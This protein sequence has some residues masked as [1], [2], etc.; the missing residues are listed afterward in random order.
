MAIPRRMAGTLA[1]T[2]ADA[3]VTVTR[4]T[5]AHLAKFEGVKPLYFSL[6]VDPAQL[7]GVPNN[8]SL[9]A[10]FNFAASQEAWRWWITGSITGAAAGAV[11]ETHKELYVPSGTPLLYEEE[12]TV[13]FDTDNT[14]GISSLL[15]VF[16]YDI[17]TTSELEM[18]QERSRYI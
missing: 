2:G 5:G 9:K 16:Y 12:L 17:V 14:G 8:F 13:T 4:Q 15:Y 10:S 11:F 6:S 18:V 7:R 3:N 1:Q